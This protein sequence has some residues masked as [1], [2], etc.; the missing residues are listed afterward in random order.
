MNINKGERHYVWSPNRL[1]GR[2]KSCLLAL[3]FTCIHV[4]SR[5]I[6]L[7]RCLWLGERDRADAGGYGSGY[8]AEGVRLFRFGSDEERGLADVAGD[9]DGRVERDC[10]EERHTQAFGCLL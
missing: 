3:T 6:W 7:S 8:A 10:A 5:L 9:A 2:D 1:D 4:H